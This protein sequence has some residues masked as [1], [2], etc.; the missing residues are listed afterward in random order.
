[1]KELCMVAL[2]L[3]G[4]LFDNIK[5]GNEPVYGDALYYKYEKLG[6]GFSTSTP[7]EYTVYDKKSIVDGLHRFSFEISK[8][9]GSTSAKYEIYVNNKLTNTINIPS[10]T[11]ST[12]TGQLISADLI[13]SKGD[14]VTIKINYLKGGMITWHYKTIIQC[15]FI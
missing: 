4:G 2:G 13:L 15:Q 12:D 14:R 5:L 11:F 3:L 10:S 7:K 6:P 1:M 8:S 9:S